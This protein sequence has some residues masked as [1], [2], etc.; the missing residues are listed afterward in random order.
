[1]TTTASLSS[2]QSPFAPQ[3]PAHGHNRVAKAIS[4]EVSA[5]TISASDGTALTSALKS[6][7]SSLSADRSAASSTSAT[8]STADQAQ[9]LDPTQ[10]K[11]KVDGLID[12]QVSGGT[13]TSAQADTLKQ[14][15]ASG[16]TEA[17][18]GVGGA[19]KAHGG[20]HHGGGAP[21]TTLDTPTTGSAATD[22]TASTTDSA[23]LLDSFIKQLQSTQSTA[24]GYASSGSAASR[25]TTSAA[26]L[27]DFQA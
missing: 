17:S 18:Q 5:G 9:R 7:D 11:T 10:L 1:M 16:G 19:Q 2:S 13:L 6:I 8:A 24:S 20:H 12:A 23:S 21:P 14:I 26:L 27:L 25:S 3:R 15:F 4:G 22:A